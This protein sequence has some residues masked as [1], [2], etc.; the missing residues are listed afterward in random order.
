MSGDEIKPPDMDLEMDLG[1]LITDDPCP[2]CVSYG[3]GQICRKDVGFKCLNACPLCKTRVKPSEVIHHYS[4]I[5]MAVWQIKGVCQK[6]QLAHPEIAKNLAS[7][8]QIPRRELP[9]R[10]PGE[11]YFIVGKPPLSRPGGLVPIEPPEGQTEG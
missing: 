8:D 1:A 6:C 11:N 9:Q 10:D 2:H 5:A 4:A 3:P 7:G